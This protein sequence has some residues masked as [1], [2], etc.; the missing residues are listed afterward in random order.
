MTTEARAF[1]DQLDDL[2]LKGDQT[3]RDVM[4]VLTALRSH[5]GK[6][7]TFVK[8]VT[9]IP[10]RR[11]ALPKC[12]AQFDSETGNVASDAAATVYINGRWPELADCLAVSPTG[13]SHAGAPHE[14]SPHSSGAIRSA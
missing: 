3:A 5:D 11:A 12:A 2:C 4:A 9:T 7:H 6:G 1:L 13:S 10:I 14:H 8:A